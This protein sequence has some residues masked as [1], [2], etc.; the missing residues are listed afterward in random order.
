[1]IA[2]ISCFF[3]P[4]VRSG[5]AKPGVAQGKKEMFVD[6]DNGDYCLL[7]SGSSEGNAAA[8]EA[9]LNYDVCTTFGVIS[10]A[11]LTLC[12]LR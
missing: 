6:A 7:I 1:V 2:R 9:P 8:A 4:A 12:C 3:F 11:L 10:S 5:T